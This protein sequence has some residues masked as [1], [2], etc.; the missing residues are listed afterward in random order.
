MTIPS[1]VPASTVD[2]AET[3]RFGAIAQ[4]VWDPLGKFRPLHALNPV[5]LRFLRDSLAAHFGTDTATVRPLAGLR[6]VDIGCG[7]GLLTEPL[8]RMGAEVVGVDAAAENIAVAAAHAADAGLDIDYRC[9][10]AEALAASGA[11]FDAVIA[12]EIIEHVADV[13]FFMQKSTALVRPG[14]AF[15]VA[16][17]NRTA[18]SLL[19]AKIGAEYVLRWLPVGTHD[20]RRFL[21]PSEIAAHLRRNGLHVRDS[22]GMAYS[23]F[24][25]EWRL[26]RDLDVNYALFAAKPAA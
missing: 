21:K 16:T 9:T 13:G 24:T 2:P 26:S 3:Q 7:G 12:M 15:A 25:D 11:R 19:L 4:E 6:I 20:W 1:A 14:G 23:P 5:R 10:T 22:A 17:I 18:K 8:A